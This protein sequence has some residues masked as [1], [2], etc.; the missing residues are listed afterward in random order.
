MSLAHCL[1]PGCRLGRTRGS[2]G[3]RCCCSW[4]WWTEPPS[5][6]WPWQEKHIKVKFTLFFYTIRDN[7]AQEK[8]GKRPLISTTMIWHEVWIRQRRC[9]FR[10]FLQGADTFSAGSVSIYKHSRAY[11]CCTN[12]CLHLTVPWQTHNCHLHLTTWPSPDSFLTIILRS[13]LKTWAPKKLYGGCDWVG[14][15]Y[16]IYKVYISKAFKH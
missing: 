16:S 6:W 1:T 3:P 15:P 5:P 9:L 2:P 11:H 4:C 8:K 13:W 12:Q 7:W 10:Y 14:Q